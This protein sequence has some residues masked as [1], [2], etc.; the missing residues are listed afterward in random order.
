MRDISYPDFEARKP[1]VLGPLEKV[2]KCICL[3]LPDYTPSSLPGLLG[4]DLHFRHDRAA[5][6]HHYNFQFCAVTRT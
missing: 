1:C 5:M 2:S 4:Q 6:R 3:S